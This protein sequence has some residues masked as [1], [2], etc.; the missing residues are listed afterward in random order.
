VMS[1]YPQL[2]ENASALPVQGVVAKPFDVYML[3]D[4]VDRALH[5]G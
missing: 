4:T 1:S 5:P 3:V 2:E